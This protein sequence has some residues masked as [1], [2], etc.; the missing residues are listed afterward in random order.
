[1]KGSLMAKANKSINANKNET[2][3]MLNIFIFIISNT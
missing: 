1:M 2:K 3:Y